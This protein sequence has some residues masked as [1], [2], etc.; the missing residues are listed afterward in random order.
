MR[1]AD[2]YTNG[3]FLSSRSYAAPCVEL[4][5][6]VVVCVVLYVVNDF[7]LHD[8]APKYNLLHAPGARPR[9]YDA[10]LVLRS[11]L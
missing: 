11:T 10:A 2:I 6:C 3:P 9:R 4:G 7:V 1:R 5:V 8:V